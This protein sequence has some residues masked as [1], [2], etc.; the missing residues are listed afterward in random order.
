M[1]WPLLIYIKI[2]VIILD[3]IKYYKIKVNMVNI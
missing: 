3:E 1:R 2:Y